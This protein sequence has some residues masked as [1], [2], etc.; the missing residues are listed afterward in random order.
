MYSNLDFFSIYMGLDDRIKY[1]SMKAKHKKILLP[2]YK[3]PWGI[4]VIIIASLFLIF[5]VIL[6][7]EVQSIL[8]ERKNPNLN[9]EQAKEAFLE[10]IN[11][12]TASTFGPPSAP[13]TIVVFSDFACPFCAE[14][15]AGLKEIRKKY[16]KDV[17]IIHRDFPLH[18]NS[19]SLAL[20]A[21]CAGEQKEFWNMHD[22]FFLNQD[23]LDISNLE[24]ITVMT[25]FA[26][27]LGLNATQYK[28]CLEEQRYFSEVEQDTEDV[29][30]LG[31]QGTPAWYINNTP[32]MG[33]LTAKELN[34]IVE[35]I[36]A[37]ATLNK[38]M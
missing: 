32:F 27:E 5:S 20:G 10:V 28:N 12:K 16:P 4:I 26:S 2:W 34:T 14:S 7:L 35:G 13:V 22:F 21:R 6:S 11:R 18:D 37:S 36:L 29:V 17:R 30:F 38:D 8:R 31:L 24:L 23:K 19:I 1:A 15:H 25:Q 9:K 33:K 3:K